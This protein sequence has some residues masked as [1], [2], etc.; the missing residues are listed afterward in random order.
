MN[1]LGGLL[2]SKCAGKHEK[3]AA[4]FKAHEF[5]PLTTPEQAFLDAHSLAP[6][7]ENCV[8]H[9][10]ETVKLF[11]A[12]PGCSGAPFACPL[13]QFGEHKGHAL[14]TLA[15][16]SRQKRN[17]LMHAVYAGVA[18]VPA[19]DPVPALETLSAGGAAAVA[20]AVESVPMVASART[21]ALAI[22]ALQDMLPHDMNAS[23]S[24]LTAARDALIAAVHAFYAD[25]SAQLAA[26]AEGQAT[27]L[28]Q[29]LGAADAVTESAR[30]ASTV[31]IEVRG[32]G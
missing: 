29:K 11:C 28:Q 19:A 26:A 15:D 7:P 1:G 30:T 20:A 27:E 24:K 31:L 16:L 14:A 3:K 13:C 6:P 32:K 22:Q 4:H 9:P 18:G 5:V 8:P 25:R 23:L 2:C 17:A 12:D 21:T 10:S